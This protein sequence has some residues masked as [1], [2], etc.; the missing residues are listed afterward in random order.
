[1]VSVFWWVSYIWLMDDGYSLSINAVLI[2]TLRHGQQDGRTRKEL[3]LLLGYLDAGLRLFFHIDKVIGVYRPDDELSMKMEQAP[4]ISIH[5][6][7]STLAADTRSVLARC[8]IA[9]AVLSIAPYCTV[10]SFEMDF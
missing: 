4:L 1:M 9:E 10:H 6:R 8:N 2:T 7:L 5:L 3:D